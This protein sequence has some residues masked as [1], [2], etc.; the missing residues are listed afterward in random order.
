[1]VTN[2][3]HET[4]VV[5]AFHQ[6]LLFFS[7]SGF[8]GGFTGIKSF[9]R[10]RYIVAFSGLLALLLNMFTHR[11][12]LSF[13]KEVS[14]IVE[15]WAVASG[16]MMPMMENSICGYMNITTFSEGLAKYGSAEAHRTMLDKGLHTASGN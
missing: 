13:E 4:G 7:I 12:Y 15:G 2:E 9:V 3:G 11:I 1:M 14:W 10:Y 16:P 6:G 8:I 5:K